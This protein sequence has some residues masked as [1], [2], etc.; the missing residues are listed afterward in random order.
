[1]KIVI[2]GASGF[3]GQ[4]LIP[5]LRDRGHDLLLAGRDTAKL[6]ALFPNSACCDYAGLPGAAGG[7]D[8]LLH[9]A[10]VNSD[11]ALPDEA[12]FQANVDFTCEL[13]R[14]AVQA[15][16][17]RFVNVSSIHALDPQNRSSYARS[18]R[19]AV[20]ELTAIKGIDVETIYLPLV[21]GARWAG[22]LAVLNRLP[23]D[24][25]RGVFRG[26]AAFKPTC[27][28]A[29]IAGHLTASEPGSDGVILCDDIGKNSLYTGGKRCMDLT[30][31]ALVLLLLWWL[32]LAAAVVIRM[33]TR[34]SP[35]F[36][37]A[38]VGRQGRVF[39]CYKF[40]T[41]HQGTVQA[42]THEVSSAAVTRVGAVL[43]KTK[44]DELP[45][46]WNILRNEISLIGPRPGLPVQ[47]GLIA[48]RQARGVLAVT[49][50]ISGL[51]QI[52]DIDMSDPARL[53]EWDAKY[54]ALRCLA[55]DVRIAL[56]TARGRG[57]G[58]RTGD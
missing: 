50:G 10:V 21:Y 28:V 4:L 49:P 6:R 27:H 29:R 19:Q 32:L 14:L 38:R 17:R 30:F 9:L 46:V 2:T 54:I 25:A 26:L 48:A 1:M 20:T 7:Y 39:T 31:A 56:A 8:L 5:Q 41:M 36:R 37:Q 35:L 15:D 58:D 22:R 53:A 18:K 11:S 12:M 51:A 3:V 16:I 43:R 42:G 45:Q 44:L 13:A 34:G 33:E 40:R 23:K 57:R 55:L 52:N 24:V 47:T